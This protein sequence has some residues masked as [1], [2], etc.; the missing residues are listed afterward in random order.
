MKLGEEADWDEERLAGSH[1]LH[2][3]GLLA[4]HLTKGRETFG[5]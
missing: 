1:Y 5:L 2:A 3:Y 4:C